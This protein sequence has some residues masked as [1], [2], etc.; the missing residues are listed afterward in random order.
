MEKSQAAALARPV[1]E[2]NFPEAKLLRRGKVRD[3]YDAGENLAIVSTDRLSAFDVVFPDPIPWK[4]AVLNQLSKYW[5]N[6]T[7]HIVD[8]HFVSSAV[9]MLPEEFHKHRAVLEGRVSLVK[10]TEPIRLECVVRGYLTGSGWSSYEKTGEVCGI[11]LR[12]GLRN[13]ERLD[14]PIFTPTTKED[15]GHDRPVNAKEA[16][17]IVGGEETFERLKD[18]SIR[19]YECG[20]EYALS[21]GIIIADTKF[22]FGVLKGGIALIDEALT[23][24]SSRFWPTASYGVGSNPPSYDKQ[25]VRDYVK[26]LGWNEEPPAPRLSREIIE[27]TSKRY[28]EAYSRLTG[29]ELYYHATARDISR[30]FGTCMRHLD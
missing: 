10:K 13:A 20:A 24:D 21:R 28:L 11:G 25:Y 9:M 7:R 15:N 14:E 4:G 5:M 22:E 26:S 3:V 30:E 29:R 12:K 6:K 1:Y 23:P 17:R 27:G 2:T 18:Y 16:A 19:L 8:N